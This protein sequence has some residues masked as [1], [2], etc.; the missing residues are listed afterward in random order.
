MA[1][2]LKHV[3]ERAGVSLQT[4][5]QCL[6]EDGSK[7]HLYSPETRQRVRQAAAELG[8]RAN[9]LARAMA[10]GQF[11]IAT[12]VLGVDPIRSAVFESMMFGLHDELAIHQM[13][14]AIARLPDEKLSDSR[15]MSRILKE[16]CSD[17]LLINYTD[18][19]PELLISII[20]QNNLPAIWIN[21]RQDWDCVY[22]DE[23]DAGVRATRYLL[24]MGHKR[25]AFVDLTHGQSY[26]SPHYSSIE[27]RSG[28]EHA[29]RQAGLVPRILWGDEGVCVPG[30]QRVSVVR[31]WLA[32]PDRPT[33]LI[34]YKGNDAIVCYCAASSLSLRV[35]QDLSLVAFGDKPINFLGE[36][37]TTMQL[38][39]EKMG[40][41]AVDM[42]I[43]KISKPDKLLAP[44][45][46]PLLFEEGKSCAP[47]TS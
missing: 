29:M 12:L 30:E 5:S 47:F 11:G 27:R 14:L 36:S 24:Q 37:F 40:R 35:P 31:Q 15:V 46:L 45:R 38:P 26:P 17:G 41:M 2:T 8:Y 13:Q 22:P 25:I 6:R 1:V 32:S 9:A 4:V 10:R 20:S 42:L 19:I 34:A 7:L 23:F 39:E 18:K 3:A 21:S 16:R 33:A 44:C 28:Y 43:A